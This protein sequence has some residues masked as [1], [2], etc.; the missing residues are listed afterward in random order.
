MSTEPQ[1]SDVFFSYA[2]EDEKLRDE[3]AAHLRLMERQHLIRTWH[4]RRIGAGKD[5]R[6][7]IDSHL[8][9]AD[10]ILLLISADFL[11]SDYCYDLE[12]KRAME[13][14]RKGEAVVIPLILRAVDWTDSPIG[15]LQALPPDGK[16]VTSYPDRDEAYRAI[17]VGIKQAVEAL[18]R[19]RSIAARELAG[20]ELPPVDQ[21]CPPVLGFGVGVSGPMQDSS[22]GAFST[23]QNRLKGVWL[24]LGSVVAGILLFLL[25]KTPAVIVVALVVLFLLL[26]HPV[27]N[28]W[29][30]DRS[31]G[32]RIAALFVLGAALALVGLAVWPVP[33]VSPAPNPVADPLHPPALS[34]P[35]QGST[36][37]RRVGVAPIQKELAPRVTRTDKSTVDTRAVHRV[38][39]Q[40]KLSAAERKEIASSAQTEAAKILNCIATNPKYD[41]TFCA[42]IHGTGVVSIRDRLH[43]HRVDASDL[44]AVVRQLESRPTIE[45]LKR[46]AVILR[47]LADDLMAAEQLPSP[48]VPA[49]D[50][51]SQAASGKPS[52]D[53]KVA[54]EQRKSEPPL[55][56]RRARG[57]VKWFNA[58]KGYGFITGEDG[59]DVYLHFSAIQSG[60]RVLDEGELVEYT[61]VR[62]AKGS[63]AENVRRLPPEKTTPSPGG[64]VPARPSTTESQAPTPEDATLHWPKEFKIDRR[65]LVQFGQRV[66]DLSAQV[67]ICLVE[68]LKLYQRV[69]RPEDAQ[70][71]AASYCAQLHGDD[72]IGIRNWLRGEGVPIPQ[73][74]QDLVARLQAGASYKD[75]QIAVKM[76][77]SIGQQSV[78]KGRSP[79]H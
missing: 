79:S 52:T 45:V 60:N 71:E 29:W 25:P 4:D 32:R 24:A 65:E 3:L 51:D 11:A 74:L 41:A 61:L 19:D 78:S 35:S 76:V 18:H 37:A 34:A 72:I 63:Q 67:S 12:M 48:A 7:Q 9:H 10:V 33:P 55:M 40:G 6:E 30:I 43:N 44:D 66:E 49:Q 31:L 70:A 5:W 23:Q 36:S 46:S 42:D 17:T 62:G 38:S 68:Q 50:T 53:Q 27:W 13:R 75:L 73:A 26:L 1:A 58:A 59:N 15:D 8:E 54:S 22:G 77:D 28:F 14:H 39:D 16:P 57:T 47:S 21:S 69:I 2:H 56:A 64:T 20:A